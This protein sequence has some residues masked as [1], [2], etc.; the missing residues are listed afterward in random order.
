MEQSSTTFCIY[1]AITKCPTLFKCFYL[2]VH[3]S[4]ATLNLGPASASVSDEE[5]LFF[6]HSVLSNSLWPRG[7]QQHARPPCPSPTPGVLPNPC[8]WS[9]WC[10][11]TISSSVAPFAS[12]PQ[13]FPAPGSLPMSQL[14][15]SG[16]QRIGV[17]ASTPVLPMNAQDWFPL[18]GLLGS[19]CSLRDSRVLPNTTV[20]KH[21]F[22]GVQTEKTWDSLQDENLGLCEDGPAGLSSLLP[23][24]IFSSAPASTWKRRRWAGRSP[25]HPAPWQHSGPHQSSPPSRTTQIASLIQ[26]HN[27]P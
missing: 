26:P 23:E 15:A 20:K 18:G 25:L 2:W 14:F 3:L 11:P 7:P 12:R 17:S 5:A 19:P 27:P 13:S 10:H 8:P 21:Q 24:P 1:G 4:L 16:G 6:R 9:R 22:F